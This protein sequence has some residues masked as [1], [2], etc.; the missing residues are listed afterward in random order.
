[1]LAGNYF[2]NYNVYFYMNRLIKLFR[3]SKEPF[4]NDY[5]QKILDDIF[6]LSNQPLNH[7]NLEEC[8]KDSGIP[9]RIMR[10]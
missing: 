9:E 10:L 3:E 7:Q 5:I 6:A 2:N 8:K 4:L 1:M